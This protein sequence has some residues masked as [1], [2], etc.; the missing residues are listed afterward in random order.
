MGAISNSWYKNLSKARTNFASIINGMLDTKLLET[1]YPFYA[2]Y[3]KLDHYIFNSIDWYKHPDYKEITQFEYLSNTRDIDMISMFNSGIRSFGV[4]NPEYEEVYFGYGSPE[5]I[6]MV[7]KIDGALNIDFNNIAIPGQTGNADAISQYYTNVINVQVHEFIN[8]LYSYSENKVIKDLFFDMLSYMY[9]EREHPEWLFKTSYIDLILMNKPLRQY[10]IYQH[11]TFDDTVEYVLEAKP[12][13]VKLRNTD[14]IYPLSETVNADVD[15]SQHMNL[16]IDL[17]GDYSRY[18]YNTY[19][20]GIAPDDEHPN[21]ADGRYEQGTLL[22]HPYEVTATKGG[23]DTGLV[24]S[25]ILESAIVR[26]DEYDSSIVGGIGTAVIDKRSFIV[27]DRLGR[28][29]F[30]HSID[31]DTV[32]AVTNEHGYRNIEIAD[33]TKFKHAIANTVYL[34]IVE[35]AEKKLEF[36]HY[37]K[38]D[39]SVL[40]INER[41]LFNGTC[42]DIQVGDTIHIVSTIE[43]IQFMAEQVDKHII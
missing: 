3:I 33:E 2:D 13:H 29:H 30:M 7:N 8:M 40:Q 1:E 31:T 5:E 38:K 10:A 19:D 6:T 35:N 37:N 28:G 41:G 43:T 34:I 32:V 23:I 21:I 42:L 9:T 11:D 27:Y 25:R 39:G 24:D 22:R 16:K 15:S 36:M 4:V 14:R 12:Y 20:G 18:D 17:G 26:V